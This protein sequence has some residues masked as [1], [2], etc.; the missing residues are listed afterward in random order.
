MKPVRLK[1]LGFRNSRHLHK[2]VA[3]VDLSTWTKRKR[4][5]RWK[6]EDGT[7]GGL[8]S[9]NV[10]TR[11]SNWPTLLAAFIESRR[12]VPFEWGKNDCC[13]FPCDGILAFTGLDPAAKMFR[14]KYHDALGAARLLKKH[15]G[16]EAV[17]EM[18]CAKYGFTECPVPLARR[19]DLVLCEATADEG[20][21]LGLCDGARSVFPGATGMVW[22][23][24]LNCRRAW[25]VG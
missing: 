5:K 20:P 19:G 10:V 9:L 22:H 12:S 13:L 18:Q 6:E 1:S 8:Q 21:A 11:L 15:G 16:V 14:G 2:L 23:P 25:R 4:F 17:A 3:G 7:A 24:T